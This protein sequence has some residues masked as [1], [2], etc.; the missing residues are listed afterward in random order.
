MGFNHVTVLLKQAVDALD[1]RPD[2]TY[3][4]CTAGG[5][6][7]TAE[8]LSRLGP[9][10][11]VI[12]VDRDPDAIA[13]LRARF[14][15][16]PRATVVQGNF[17]E[18]KQILRALGVERVQGVLADLGVSSHQ[19]DTPERG[20]SYHAEAPLDM[21]MSRSG[22]SAY[23]V[24]NTYTEAQ[25]TRVIYA[26]GEERFARSIARRICEERAKA[27][28][29]TTLQLA[30]IVK[31]AIPAR[32]RRDGGHPARRTFQALRIET[33][34]ELELLPDAVDA[35]FSVLQ[36]GGVLSVITFHSL[37][38]R[39]V[40]HAFKRYCAPCT[41]PPDAPLCVCGKKPT[42]RTAGKPVT[43][44]EAEL[45]A[46]PRSRSARLRAVEKIGENEQNEN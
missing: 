12:A 6:G 44:D 36:T 43:P 17:S 33:N 13:A 28:V 19:L 25:L 15:D 18:L 23:D 32:A 9:N 30:E 8:I 40:K 39:I 29:E 34:R 20:F 4:D 10:G 38:D 41:C 35:M 3:V 31:S 46:N 16:E 26:Y 11:R 7:H 37:E 1:V 14:Q 5:G 22:L 42:G 24:V 27:P 45:A 2:G 21:R